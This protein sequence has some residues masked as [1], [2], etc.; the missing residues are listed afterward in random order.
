MPLVDQ[1]DS[2]CKKPHGALGSRRARVVLA[3]GLCLSFGALPGCTIHRYDPKT[4]TEHVWG[5]G[6]IKM[7]VSPPNE[8]VTAVGTQVS[9]FG[10]AATNT[11]HATGLS[12]GWRRNSMLEFVADDASLSLMWPSNSFF[13]VRAGTK[14]PFLDGTQEEESHEDPTP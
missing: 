12:I 14:P 9:S 8:G 4:G 5:F 11:K 2:G 13:E 7:R 1:H 6:H 10:V 3:V